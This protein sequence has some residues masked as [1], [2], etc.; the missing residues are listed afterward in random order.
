VF[1][2]LFAGSNRNISAV[3]SGAGIRV[4]GGWSRALGQKSFNV[5]FRSEHG[6]SD[7]DYYLIPG[8]LQANGTTPTTRYRDFILR[9]GGNDAEATKLRDIFIQRL[10]QDRNLTIQEGIPAIVYLNGEY[11][12]VYNIQERY[13]D[14]YLQYKGYAANRDNVII[15]TAWDLDEGEPSDWTLFNQYT[16]FASADFTNAATYTAFCNIV[17]IQSYIDYFAAQIYIHNQDWPN[18]NFR[19]WRVRNPASEPGPYGDGKWR[20]MVYDTEFSMG[21]YAGGN[22]ADGDVDAFQRLR[23]PDKGQHADI[24]LGLMKNTEFSRRFV[25]AVMDLYNVNFNPV[26]A[27][28]K[29]DA[30]AAVYRPLMQAHYDRFGPSWAS[31]WNF[32]NDVQN[33][34]NYLNNIRSFMTNTLLPNNFSNTGISAGNLVNVTLS[35]STPGASIRINSVT[36]P[37]TSGSWTG[38]YYAVSTLPVTVTA[39]VPAGFTFTNWTVTGGTAANSTART[40]TVTLTGGNAVITANFSPN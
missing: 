11:W 37:L 7:L 1:F 25:M 6:M 18:N 29:L 5:Y 17:D 28:P 31:L 30:L 2:E 22:V 34:R 15:F 10:L 26:T 27:I 40:T 20:F 9:N 19:M 35:T 3:S 14:R 23:L 13:S 21:I 38:Q 33:I 36:P 16:A 12:G 32:D 39:N 8:A 24:F 4:R